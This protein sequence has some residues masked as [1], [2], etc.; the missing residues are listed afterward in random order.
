MYFILSGEVEVALEPTPVRLG[1]GQYFGEIALLRDTA[2]TATVTAVE[3]TELLVLEVADFRKL[4]EL[5]PDLKARIER[6]AA[7]RLGQR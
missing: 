3:D 7:E 4:I 2:R 1:K 6:I 5:H